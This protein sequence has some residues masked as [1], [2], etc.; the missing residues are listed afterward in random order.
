MI[1]TSDKL[2]GMVSWEDSLFASNAFEI[3]RNYRPVCDFCF[4]L[5]LANA[6]VVGP[7][8]RAALRE[9]LNE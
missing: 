4:L 6:N 2:F 7:V 5:Y 9:D 8:Q 1:E 3:L